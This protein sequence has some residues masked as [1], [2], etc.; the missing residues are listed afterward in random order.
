MTIQTDNYTVKVNEAGF[1]YSFYKPDHTVIA[2]TQATAGVCFGPAGGGSAVYSAATSRYNGFSSDV[3]QP[4]RTKRNHQLS[5]LTVTAGG[6][7][8]IHEERKE[9]ND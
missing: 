9:W 8:S 1:R 7:K 3:R 2:D 4:D 5:T 6:R